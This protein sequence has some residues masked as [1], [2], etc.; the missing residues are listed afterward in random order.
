MQRSAF[1]S[2]TANNP[3]KTFSQTRVQYVLIIRQLQEL[4]EE[5]FSQLPGNM[6]LTIKN[7]SFT[8]AADR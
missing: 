1:P 6:S 7:Q 5:S 8:N 3:V 2:K 4:P